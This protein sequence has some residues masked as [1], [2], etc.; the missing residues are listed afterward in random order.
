MGNT[1]FNRHIL[2]AAEAKTIQFS[3]GYIFVAADS[4][5]LLRV[6]SFSYYSHTGTLQVWSV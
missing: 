6:L 5:F 1:L 3:V 4:Y 2:R